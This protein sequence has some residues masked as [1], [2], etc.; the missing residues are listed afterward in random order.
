[1]DVE[2]FE[3]IDESLFAYIEIQFRGN[4]NGRLASVLSIGFYM[5]FQTS[6]ATFIYFC[7]SS[8]A[9]GGTD[10]SRVFKVIPD[11]SNGIAIEIEIRANR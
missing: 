6:A 7:F 2:F 3:L 5:S 4:C 8:N 1:M 11:F 10:A 9:W